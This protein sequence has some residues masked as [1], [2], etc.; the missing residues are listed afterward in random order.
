MVG[1]YQGGKTNFFEGL[2]LCDLI[3]VEQYLLLKE[4]IHFQMST[5][6][7]LVATILGGYIARPHNILI[8]FYGKQIIHGNPRVNFICG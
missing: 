2:V 3:W 4:I 5:N 6:S 8:P 7:S 1:G